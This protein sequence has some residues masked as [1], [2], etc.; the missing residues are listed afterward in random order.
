MCICI[1]VK[2]LYFRWDIME[3]PKILIVEDDVSMRSIYAEVFQS[4]NYQVLEANDGV[5]GLDMATRE[6]PDVIFTGII[7]PRM[8]GFEMITA[9][10][11]NVGTSKIPVAI[12]SHMGREMDQQRANQLGV[13]DFLTRDSVTPAETVQ[14]INALLIKGGDIFRIS[15]DTNALDAPKLAE[16]LKFNPNYQCFSCNGKMVLQLKLA[17]PKERFFEAK[18]ICPNCGWEVK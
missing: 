13:K 8:D 9:L 15:F 11:K 7:M 4:A 5:E 1:F 10:Q 6:L 3:K 17:N 16:N 14:R 2:D 12:C 18:F